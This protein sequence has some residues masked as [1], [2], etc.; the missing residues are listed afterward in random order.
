MEHSV[1]HFQNIPS[2]AEY[3]SVEY[4]TECKTEIV[5]FQPKD[6]PSPGLKTSRNGFSIDLQI[7]ITFGQ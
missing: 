7:V 1:D 3:N 5:H 6:S 4:S 2:Q